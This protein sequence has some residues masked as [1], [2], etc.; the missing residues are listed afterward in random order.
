MFRK[1]GGIILLVIGIG[2]G[3]HFFTSD[4]FDKQ[5]DGYHKALYLTDNKLVPQNDGKIVIIAGTP[6]IKKGAADHKYN[7][8]FDSPFAF[9]V[10][11]EYSAVPL[12]SQE[13]K[14]LPKGTTRTTKMKW[15]RRPIGEVQDAK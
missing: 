6:V 15:E 3:C 1:I 14:A 11:E 2:L 4:E 10:V 12:T 5:T 8:K 13:E 9:R 7:I